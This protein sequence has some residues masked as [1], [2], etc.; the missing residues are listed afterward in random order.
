MGFANA[1]R[2]GTHAHRGQDHRARKACSAWPE[3]KGRL[4]SLPETEYSHLGV[5]TGPS[6]AE[7]FWTDLPHGLWP[8]AACVA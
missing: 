7:T 2:R 4:R 6:E 5:A 1:N 3:K 8:T